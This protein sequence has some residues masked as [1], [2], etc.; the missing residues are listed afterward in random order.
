M[1]LRRDPARWAAYVRDSIIEPAIG[2][3]ILGLADIRRPAL[4]RQVFAIAVASPAQIVSLQKLQGQLQDR[5]SLETIAHYLTV[6]E[7]AYLVASLEKHAARATRRRAAPPKL[8]TLNNALIAA[9]DPRGIPERQRE[10]DR[11]GEWVEN[12]C[13]SFAW[14]SGQRVTYWREE[15]LEV[16]GVIDGSWGTWA[17]EVKTG[18]FGA[19]DVRGLLEFARRF[20]KHRPLLLCDPA[21]LPGAE[22][23]G[24]PAM[25]WRQ[26]LLDGPPRARGP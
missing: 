11:F 14:N 10:P 18:R 3:D 26:F 23:L 17:I 4:L 6:L 9:V 12:A 20:P 8:V 15:P 1:E 25:S 24:V 13:L 22:R 5:G 7:D 16:D 2:R 21:G 19:P